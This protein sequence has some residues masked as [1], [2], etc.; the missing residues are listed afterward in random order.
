MS[1]LLGVEESVDATYFTIQ[2]IGGNTAVITGGRIDIVYNTTTL[3]YN[4]KVTDDLDA[5]V[6][7]LASDVGLSTF[8]DGVKTFIVYSSVP[9]ELGRTV[10]GF[11]AIIA[12][13]VMRD[14]LV[15][16]TRL[17]YKTRYAVSEKVR[18]LNN[19]SFAATLG[20]IADF[21]ENL[22]MLQNLR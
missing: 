2:R 14:S 21:N 10:E 17:D 8:T 13:E 16:R 18:L 22:S 4:F 19:L 9:T 5:G 6:V 1:V 3:T 15:Y 7:V 11:A 12:G 20:S